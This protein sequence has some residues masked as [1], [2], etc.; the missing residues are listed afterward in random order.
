MSLL[1]LSSSVSGVFAVLSSPAL[2][3]AEDA[4]PGISSRRLSFLSAIAA[5]NDH[6]L[7]CT[8]SFYVGHDPLAIAQGDVVFLHGSFRTVVANGSTSG[9]VEASFVNRLLTSSQAFTPASPSAAALTI[10]GTVIDIKDRSFILDSACWSVEVSIMC[11]RLLHTLMLRFPRW[12]DLHTS[13]QPSTCLP[14]DD[15]SGPTPLAWAP[16]PLS[17]PSS[18]SSMPALS[19]TM[20][21]S[22]RICVLQ[23]LPHRGRQPL[24]SQFPPPR[25]PLAILGSVVSL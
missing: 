8:I 25:A 2:A 20:L 13:K 14:R 23:Q 18:L 11:W 16:Q 1:P 7:P 9:V 3:V 19:T 21:Q 17:E 4:R 24:L 12:A 22:L 15:G 5:D 6:S 10:M